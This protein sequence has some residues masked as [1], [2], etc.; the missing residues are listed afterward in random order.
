MEKE[1]LPISAPGNEGA[2]SAE[3]RA[4]I[5]HRFRAAKAILARKKPRLFS[6]SSSSREKAAYNVSGAAEHG[7][8][9]IPLQNIDSNRGSSFVIRA[10]RC[11]DVGIDKVMPLAASPGS[12][13]VDN[14][15]CVGGP[16][17]SESFFTPVRPLKKKSECYSM[18]E[19]VSFP[20]L[21]DEA[22]DDDILQQIDNVCRDK[23]AEKVQEQ[24]AVSSNRTQAS[25]SNKPDGDLENPE[26]VLPNTS[27]SESIDVQMIL[28]KDIKD[29][30]EVYLK[31][32]GS[33]NDQQLEAAC[34]DVSLPL[35][36]VAGPGSGK[37]IGPSHILAMT[38]TTAAA[39]EMRD[40]I[41]A[42]TGKE[43]AKEIN[44]S[45]FHSFSLQFCRS[46]AE[47]LGYT[48]DFLIYGHGQQRRAVIEALR[49]LESRLDDK[50]SDDAFS[51]LIL[52]DKSKKWQKFVTQSKASGMT[53]EDF[54][55]KGDE[56]GATLLNHYNDTL[57]ACNALDYHDLI[58]YSV[59]LLDDYPEVL[60]ECHKSWKAIIVD[61]FQD[62]SAMQYRLLRLLAS[63]GC[64][65][66]VGDN[67]QSIFSFNGADISGFDSFRMDFP[68]YK[69]IGLKKN[70]R[71][72]RCIVEAASALIRNN[73]KRCHIKNVLTENA[74]G[75]KISVKECQSEDSQ[76]AFVIDKI[77]E[78]TSDN[79]TTKCSFKNIAILYRRQ[80]S[81][82]V[83][84]SAFR[85]RRIPF[86][87]HGVAFYRKKIIKAIMS[88]LKTPLPGC[89]DAPF[90]QV[91]KTLLQFEKEEKK[92]VI[93]HIDKIATVRGDSFISA[94]SDIFSAKI[95]GTFKRSQLS[96][97]RKVLSTLDMISK[98]VQRE[99]SISAV[100]TSVGN[101][102]PQRY[103]LEKRAV[104]NAE[105]G[106]LLNEDNDLRSVLQFLLDDVNDF[107]SSKY[108]PNQTENGDLMPKRGCIDVL[109]AFIDY[110]SEREKENFRSRRHDNED[111]V[112]LTTIHQSKG[113][114]WD[115][116]FIVKVN[117]S[118]IPLLHEHNGVTKEKG[119]SIEEERRLLYVA[120]TRAKRKLFLLYL[121][122]DSN[123]Q[124]LQPS[125]FLR[126]IP[127]HLYEVQDNV[128][129]D[130]VTSDMAPEVIEDEVLHVGKKCHEDKCFKN[131]PCDGQKAEIPKAIEDDAQYGNCFLR[132]SNSKWARKKAFQDPK[133][134]IDKVRFVIDERLQLKQNKHKDALHDLKSCL[135]TDEA[136][137]FAGY[138]LRCE[139][140]DPD[141]RAHIMM[142]K[143][144]YFQKLRMENVMSSSAPTDK[145]IAY[146]RTLGCTIVPESRLQA[147]HLIEQY[148][149]L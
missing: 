101:L 82:K 115:I 136:I 42:V 137:Q 90:R 125:R 63:H 147:S 131:Y 108:L 60:E 66:V 24:V 112:S 91:F 134:L 19:H 48:S 16:L 58:N 78:Y 25:N 7:V 135:G 98:L 142:E 1:N 102:V 30:P 59:K 143:Q 3:Q 129:Q 33:L 29:M 72:T 21:P 52:K 75:D 10:S 46:H 62:T 106:K 44:I 76:C 95:S 100:I 50:T 43:I 144:Q 97:G 64:L 121:L 148:K 139:Q 23:S 132:R 61:E 105:D 83:F 113:L 118:E 22:F 149:S 146:L 55:K 4:R 103:L 36:V 6:P 71:S 41:S 94:A 119:N 114:E 116:V 104:V 84:Q 67:D 88:M 13:I 20:I 92:K 107:L 26:C 70:Y 127:D 35:I 93:E 85:T 80:V 79:S 77:L 99:E 69:E 34:S 138:V 14:A 47:K 124:M 81:G 87:V 17:E 117:E 109:K 145:Q 45:T 120:M 68:R 39:S 31:Y 56:I 54:H 140:I 15:T 5:S 74:S 130:R 8:D 89:E 141:K 122:M 57:R 128:M 110:I 2:L 40:R 65:T 111:G 86:N 126:E 53:P 73:V 9:R 96:Q 28:N 27:S 49:L 133:R 37:G 11:S 32:V 51:P 123:W 18:P 38:F 12:I